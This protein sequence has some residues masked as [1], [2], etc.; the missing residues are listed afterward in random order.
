MAFF[1]KVGRQVRS[2]QRP[3]VVVQEGSYYLTA[4]GPACPKFRLHSAPDTHSQLT[5]QLRP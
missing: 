3:T 2:L 4:P 1:G 5:F